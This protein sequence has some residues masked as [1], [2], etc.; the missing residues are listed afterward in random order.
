M[1]LYSAKRH[2]RVRGSWPVNVTPEA[3][4]LLAYLAQHDPTISIIGEGGYYSLPAGRSYPWSDYCGVPGGIPNRNTVYTTL[5][6]AGQAPT[7]AQSVTAAQINAA[8]A[9]SPSGQV[10]LLNPGTYSGSG[11]G[12]GNKSG[13]TLRGSGP[14][15]TILRHNASGSLFED[16]AYYLTFNQ[17]GQT[18]SSGYT[19]GSMSITLSST[20][21]AG[22]QIGRHIILSETT[23][24]AN[25]WGT[26]IGVFEGAECSGMYWWDAGEY[27]KFAFATRITN[28]VGNTIY[29]A[30]PIPV[31]FSASQTP[32]AHWPDRYS[33]SLCGI[34]NLTMDGAGS[35]S[36]YSAVRW[37]NADRCWIKDVEIKNFA[38]G[39]NGTIATYTGV[40]N[41]FRRIYIH[42]CQDFPNQ[43]DGQG[44]ALTY[45]D[46]NSMIV[47]CIA[48]NLASL[49]QGAGDVVPALLYN[50]CRTMGRTTITSN[51]WLNPAIS[52]HA[53]QT[54]MGLHEGNVI[55]AWMHDGYHGSGSHQTI[56]R[57]HINGLTPGYSTPYERRMLTLCRGSYYINVVGNVLGDTSWT[58]ARY[59][60]TTGSGEDA[61]YGLGFPNASGVSLT[62]SVSWPE[63]SG[64]YPDANVAGTIIRHANY[65]HFHH[66]V[67]YKDGEVTS[68]APSLFYDSKPSWFG[69]LAWPAI[70]PD[71]SGYVTN[72]PAQ[73]RWANYQSSGELDDLFTDVS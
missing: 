52:H 17:T 51:G 32:R 5:G 4:A 25:K 37:Y 54:Y 14:G 3:A 47:D 22:F 71:V 26:N 46:S 30:S 31:S 44:I 19:Y 18:I 12:F 57:N 8:L 56:F 16:S 29:L 2:A 72:I 20:P 13:G 43:S 23:P 1:A 33:L 50:Y 48:N 66:S 35:S 15:Q 45:C 24:Y 73:Q 10:V 9:A 60:A 40:Q 28:I 38:G 64:S 49:Y 53:P 59:E 42:D 63:Y 62:P 21:N 36:S 69:S 61:A 11:I 7:Y 41:E 27:K 68:I 6:V 55:S 67:V 65:D 58:M 39:D 70:G 34:E